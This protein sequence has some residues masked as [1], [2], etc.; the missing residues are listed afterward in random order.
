MSATSKK[1]IETFV[2]FDLETTGLLTSQ[3]V[4]DIT[5]LTLLA[6]SN[7]SY[8][9]LIKSQAFENLRVVHKLS[10]PIRPRKTI[11]AEAAKITSLYLCGYDNCIR[12]TI[13]SLFMIHF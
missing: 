1:T 9:D 12:I 7:D 3:S 10:I 2:F 5:E 13:K 8:N 11:H 6:V 4:P